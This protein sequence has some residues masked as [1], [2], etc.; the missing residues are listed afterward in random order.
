MCKHLEVISRYIFFFFHHNVLNKFCS[1]SPRSAESSYVLNKFYRNMSLNS[2][3][4]NHFRQHVRPLNHHILIA[5]FEGPSSQHL[6]TQCHNGA[7]HTKT[8]TNVMKSTAAIF[9]LQHDSLMATTTHSEQQL[10]NT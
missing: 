9:C 10:L 8:N 6:T 7:F 5:L 1:P 3:V 2:F 4:A